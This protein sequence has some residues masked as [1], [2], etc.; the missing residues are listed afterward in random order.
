MPLTRSQARAL[1]LAGYF[2]LVVATLSSINWLL[3]IWRQHV[4]QRDWPAATATIYDMREHSR[5]VQPPSIGSRA[6]WVFWAEFDVTLDVPP[7]R[8]PTHT[9]MLNGRP[10][11]CNGVVKTPEV[12][13]RP[14]AVAW[15]TRHKLQSQ[16]TV[17]YDPQNGRLVLAGESISDMWP[18]Y[19]ITVT[20]VIVAVGVF[21]LAIGNNAS[22]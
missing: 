13:S 9:V 15:F 4:Q 20:L 14:D 16:I 1:R 5:E 10:S 21:L 22:E 12:R 7:E 6:Y 2:A 8:C 19:E 18:W 17:R 3:I 11:S